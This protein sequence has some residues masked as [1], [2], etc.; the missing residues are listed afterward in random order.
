M[1]VDQSTPCNPHS[2]LT[3]KTPY[4]FKQLQYLTGV[5]GIPTLRRCLVFVGQAT[6]C[7]HHTT[8]TSQGKATQPW[9]WL[10][11][12]EVLRGAA[13]ASGSSEGYMEDGRTRGSGRSL[14]LRRTRTSG[15]VVERLK[16]ED[17]QWVLHNQD[18][19]LDGSRKSCVSSYGEQKQTE[20]RCSNIKEENGSGDPANGRNAG[21]RETKEGTGKRIYQSKEGTEEEG[22]SAWVLI[23]EIKS[24]VD[25]SNMRIGGLWVLLSESDE[26]AT[27]TAEVSQV[28]CQGSCGSELPEQGGLVRQAYASSVA[29][30]A[31]QRNRV[32][33]SVSENS[34]PAAGFAEASDKERV[35][36]MDV[37]VDLSIPTTVIIWT[38]D[39]LVTTKHF[40]LEVSPQIIYRS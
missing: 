33:V 19:R 30:Q 15:L 13:N 2:A 9:L 12:R 18:W 37:A 7:R 21:H 8:V 17:R 26:L 14:R 6:R 25:P 16:K 35:G 11:C 36:T 32:A 4:N 28:P 5:R 24:G 34:Q 20:L 38:R 23:S 27:V 31:T 10:T 3:S 22:V 1:L 39:I 40:F 29:D